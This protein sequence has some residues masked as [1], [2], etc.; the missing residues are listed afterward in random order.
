MARVTPS[1]STRIDEGSIE[2]LG[3]PEPAGESGAGSDIDAAEDA[4]GAV[5]GDARTL[6]AE[7]AGNIGGEGVAEA[8]ALVKDVGVGEV[9]DGGAGV[10]GH[11]VVILL[12]VGADEAVAVGVGGGAGVGGVADGV[13]GAEGVGDFMGEEVIALGII[14]SD[15]E[16]GDLVAPGAVGV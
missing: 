4:G 11:D 6:F 7:E 12:A 3:I 10:V 15:D 13:G 1:M 9:G 2:S 16:V 8:L 14:G 5:G